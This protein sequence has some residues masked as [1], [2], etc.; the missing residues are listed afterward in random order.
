MAKKIRTARFEKRLARADAHIANVK[1]SGTF[2][3]Q[4]RRI[5]SAE[6]ARYHEI[7]G[8]GRSHVRRP[9]FDLNEADEAAI[10]ARA[11]QGVDRLLK[12]SR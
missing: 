8:A 3:Q 10:F 4:S 5:S 9:F 1:R 2:I 6:K 7:D 12:E 11:Q